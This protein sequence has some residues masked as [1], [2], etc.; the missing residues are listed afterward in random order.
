[1][2][3]VFESNFYS[4]EQIYP[5]RLWYSSKQRQSSIDIFQIIQRLRWIVFRISF[6]IGPFS[7]LLLNFS[8]V[9]QNNFS[10]VQSWIGATNKTFESL[11]DQSWQITRMIQMSMSKQNHIDARRINWMGL[12]IFESQF[13]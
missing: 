1:M 12:P 3:I 2:T 7:F 9:F 8:T 4:F 10:N 13:F 6:F 11:F 5:L